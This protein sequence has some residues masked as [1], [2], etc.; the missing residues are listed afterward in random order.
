MPGTD[1]P[2]T[3]TPTTE[4]PTA[5]EPKPTETVESV[6]YT[7]LTLPTILLVYISVVA[8]SLKKQSRSNTSITS[9]KNS[10]IQHKIHLIPTTTY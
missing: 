1:A 8:G 4:P 6:H 9:T 10:H 7:H 5:T 2:A 3:D